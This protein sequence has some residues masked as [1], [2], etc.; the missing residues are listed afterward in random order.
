MSCC[1]L[2]EEARLVTAI[3]PE[4]I[5]FD[6]SSYT[7]PNGR[8]FEWKGRIFR[9]VTPESA[10]LYLELWQKGIFQQLQDKGW[11]VKTGI[12][13]LSLNGYALVLEHQRIPFLTYCVEWPAP[14]LRDAALLTLDIGI[15]L[16]EDDVALQDAYPWNVFFEGTRP[17][18]IDFG[19]VVKVDPNFI[20]GAYY[21]F[22]RFFLYPLYLCTFGKGKVARSLLMHFFDGVWE[23]DLF[24]ELSIIQKLTNPRLF[25]KQI[26]PYYLERLHRS[27][28]VPQRDKFKGIS[29]GLQKYNTRE[30]RRGFLQNLRR[31]VESMEFKAG[32][33][34]WVG[35]YVE[36]FPSEQSSSGLKER[37][38][39]QILERFRPETVLDMGCNVG[40]YSIMAAEKGARV[41]AFDRDEPSITRLYH[42][43][44]DK[45]LYIIP[46]VMD[47][48][49]PTP[50]F[51]WCSKQ[52]PPA[53]ERLRCDMVF[54]L[55]VIHHLIFN[56]WQNFGRIA[57]ALNAFSKRWALVEFIPR[58]DEYIKSRWE[59]RFE[60][61]TMDNLTGALRR[62][63]A[64]IEVF[65]SHPSGRK[66]LLCQK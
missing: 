56:Y 57:E 46:L 61:Y 41:V 38:I 30:A 10:P 14:M 6:L 18:F 3:P 51:G 26:L 60:W 52:F 4:E 64:S 17:I 24:G 37:V 59:G 20:W 35:Y 43:V 63:F 40:R 32:E 29:K 28:P 33:S 1:S 58:E 65:D 16:A 66:L 45:N 44:R 39:S 36:R 23:E 31:D 55:A 2:K 34:H 50:G 13:P 7:D 15:V 12:A 11:L 25:F 19:S 9:A 53:I 49:N 54:C 48:L 22:C 21:Q 5:S 8:V 47:F 42:E 27:L 62:Y